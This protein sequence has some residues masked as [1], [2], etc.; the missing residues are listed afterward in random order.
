MTSL[1]D[2]KEVEKRTGYKR[3]TVYKLTAQGALPQPVKTG[4]RTTRWYE[5][6]IDKWVESHRAKRDA[7]SEK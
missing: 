7:P 6:E 2:V 1:I 4:L 5:D 3:S